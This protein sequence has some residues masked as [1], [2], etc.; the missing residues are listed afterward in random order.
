MSENMMNSYTARYYKEIIYKRNKNNKNNYRYIEGNLKIWKKKP[1]VMWVIDVEGLNFD[2]LSGFKENDLFKNRL[3]FYD[4]K[5][6]DQ[7]VFFIDVYYRALNGIPLKGCRTL[8]SEEVKVLFYNLIKTKLNSMR[9]EV[10]NLVVKSDI[11][12]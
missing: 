11:L 6:L 2:F 3:Y 9:E 1:N 7:I 8:I 4:E 12:K 5:S 10:R